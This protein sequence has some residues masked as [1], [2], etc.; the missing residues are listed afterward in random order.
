MI[1]PSQLHTSNRHGWIAVREET[2]QE[3][4]L[5]QIEQTTQPLHD[6]LCHPTPI[7]GCMA[8]AIAPA[9]EPA[10]RA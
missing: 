4:N 2:N 9:V 6:P 10:N 1:G 7:R 3:V 5:Y 8:Q